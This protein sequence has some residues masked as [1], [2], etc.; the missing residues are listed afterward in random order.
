MYKRQIVGRPLPVP[1]DWGL[2]DALVGYLV[3]AVVGELTI[4]RPR[5]NVRIASLQPRM[6]SDYLPTSLL[7]GSRAT[8]AA[9]LLLVTTFQLLN[10]QAT[11]PYA[12]P[13]AVVIGT[14]ILAVLLSVEL[15]QRLIVARPQ[16]AGDPD[17]IRAD[18]AIRS[19]SVHAL[20]GAGAALQLII[21]SVHVMSIGAISESRFGMWALSLIHI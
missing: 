10:A 13:N 21:C 11:H 20:A 12:G 14:T 1:F 7:W 8:A 18:D 17:V 3:G 5:G 9:A 15:L 19:A 4:K 16:P 2:I 6:L